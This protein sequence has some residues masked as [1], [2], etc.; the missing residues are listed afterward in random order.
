MSVKAKELQRGM[1]QPLPSSVEN[2]I[3]KAQLRSLG[4]AEI[5]I[6]KD[7]EDIWV[8]QEDPSGS[9]LRVQEM[10]IKVSRVGQ[11][12]N[13]KKKGLIGGQRN[14]AWTDKH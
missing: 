10:K 11:E 3:M 8:T 2:V 7:G 6:L 1:T 9:S 13:F 14:I 5:S 4:S 12:D